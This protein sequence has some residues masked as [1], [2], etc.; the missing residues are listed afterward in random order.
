VL[1]IGASESIGTYAVRLAS[2]T[3]ALVHAVCSGRS[4]ELVES[5]GAGR[6]FD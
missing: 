6:V 5:L 3:G 1:V 4:A 2:H